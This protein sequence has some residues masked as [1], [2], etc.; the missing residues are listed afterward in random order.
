MP[1]SR[2]VQIIIQTA[3]EEGIDPGLALAAA[4]VESGF[5]ILAVGDNGQSYG[6]M[7][8][9]VKGRGAQAPRDYDPI[10]QVRRFAAEVRN[11]LSGG[12]QGTIGEIIA[13]AQRPF[14]QAEAAK[15][16]QAAYQRWSG[17]KAPS[18]VEPMAG[19][20]TSLDDISSLVSKW[21]DA[22]GSGTLA[23]FVQH[24]IEVFGSPPS[25]KI[26]VS[27]GKTASLGEAFNQSLKEYE[28]S[29]DA[30]KKREALNPQEVQK[31]TAQP[32][33]FDMMTP[34][35][36]TAWVQGQIPG[37][38]TAGSSQE[39]R[40]LQGLISRGV[41]TQEAAD[42][43]A[44][45]GLLKG[46]TGGAST[47]TEFE[48]ER[49]LREAQ[50]AEIYQRMENEPLAQYLKRLSTA[51]S[52]GQLQRDVA[53]DKFD[54]AMQVDTARRNAPG[55]AAS[56]L[57]TLGGMAVPSN[58]TFPLTGMQTEP[59][60]FQPFIDAVMPQIPQEYMEMGPDPALMQQLAQAASK[61]QAGTP[62][63]PQ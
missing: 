4:E 11:V 30:R 52:I 55:E 43:L 19:G 49:G 50:T 20:G 35:Q 62:P 58:Y 32:W 3:L 21:M 53:K 33:Y 31:E 18:G 48:S 38:A 61:M 5:N 51:V 23:D 22:G 13:A 27:S 45:A 12:Y 37:G 63:M 56:A 14:N 39:E 1:D 16:Y 60:S 34:E 26:I 46:L 7:Q 47:R 15:K 9:H 10:N 8:E 57:K 40:Q 28:Q 41:L 59:Q 54:R 36:Q 29:L 17:P 6:I 2:L 25:Q 24:H 42:Q 44:L